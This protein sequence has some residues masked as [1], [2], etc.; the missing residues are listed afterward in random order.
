MATKGQ[1]ALLTKY[2]FDKLTTTDYHPLD[3]RTAIYAALLEGNIKNPNLDYNYGNYNTWKI[4]HQWRGNINNIDQKLQSCNFTMNNDNEI[5]FNCSFIDEINTQTPNQIRNIYN[6]EISLKTTNLSTQ[7]WT[8][9]GP[10]NIKVLNTVAESEFL[11]NS[12]LKVF[13]NDD[14]E[15]ISI[16]DEKIDDDF[17]LNEIHVKVKSFHQLY[18]SLFDSYKENTANEQDKS[19]F[20][21]VLGAAIFYLPHP[22]SCWDGRISVKAINHAIEGGKLVKDHIIPRKL[23]SKILLELPKPLSIDEF[24]AVYWEVYSKFTYVTTKEN[25]KLRNYYIDNLDYNTAASKSEIE[26][27]EKGLR[28]PTPNA[29]DLKEFLGY[30][31]NNG[32]K[33]LNINDLNKLSDEFILGI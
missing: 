6:E 5:I 27:F 24:N 11:H 7:L 31:I 21:T 19:F 33:S 30:L 9:V 17:P 4:D 15:P 8:N 18:I 2:I 29:R 14:E 23:A 25:Y 13:I 12:I 3:W 16:N 10:N 1:I 22:E 28:N 20:Q 26:W 32:R